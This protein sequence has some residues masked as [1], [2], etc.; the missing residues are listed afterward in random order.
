MLPG[1]YQRGGLF[2]QVVDALVE[3][4]EALVR[5]LAPVEAHVDL[6]EH[7]RQLEEREHLVIVD[8]R[9]IAPG[10]F[11]VAAEKLIAS[12]PTRLRRDR[13]FGSPWIAGLRPI[14][15]NESEIHQRIA[16]GR[17]LPIE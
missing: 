13:R 3:M 2:N 16:D 9:K 12:K 5:G 1:L 10:F 6:L 11:G 8:E 14:A 17:H 4:A 7:H 15:E